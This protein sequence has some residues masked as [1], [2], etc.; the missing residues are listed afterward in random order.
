MALNHVSRSWSGYCQSL[1][2]SFA[3]WRVSISI[4][5]RDYR[6]WRRAQSAASREPTRSD[7]RFFDRSSATWEGSQMQLHLSRSQKSGMMGG[8]KFIIDMR[9][10][11]TPEEQQNVDRF[12][13]NGETLFDIKTNQVGILSGRFVDL[14]INV[15]ELVRGKTLECSNASE[16]VEADKAIRAAG[17]T[18]SRLLKAAAKFQDEE[19]VIAFT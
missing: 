10:E 17:E 18:L 6:A 13:M 4:S 12:K 1:H 11:L 7:S 16:I 2:P 14:R 9:A 15:A 3:G 8:V 5:W 19:E